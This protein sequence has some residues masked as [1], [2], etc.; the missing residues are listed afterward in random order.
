MKNKGLYNHSH[1]FMLWNCWQLA[2]T[3]V[4]PILLEL[5]EPVY[6]NIH[7]KSAGGEWLVF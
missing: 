4:S 1:D 5:I 6:L 2:C 3:E 7:Y